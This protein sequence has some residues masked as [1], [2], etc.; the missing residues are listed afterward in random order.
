MHRFL[1]IPIIFGLGCLSADFDD[2]FSDHP[3][4]N[5]ATVDSLG[6]SADALSSPLSDGYDPLFLIASPNDSPDVLVTDGSSG[7]SQDSDFDPHTVTSAL[8]SLDPSA[9]SQFHDGSPKFDGGPECGFPRLPACCLFGDLRRCKWYMKFD[10]Y[11]EDTDDY[12][13]CEQVTAEGQGRNCQGVG[14]WPDY[15]FEKVLDIL[16]S[17]ALPG[18]VPGVLIPDG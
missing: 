17:P 7:G 10:D 1:T 12:F 16:R 5:I 4:V 13:C 9:S 2:L 18:S 11:C 8:L 15:W 14:G 3:D 6:P